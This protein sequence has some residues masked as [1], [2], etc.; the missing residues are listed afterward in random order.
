MRKAKTKQTYDELLELAKE[1]GVENNALFLSA[2]KQY[3]LQMKV[4][5][6]IR[7]AID[8]NESMTCEKVYR[9]KEKNLYADPLI[10]EL[11]RHTDSANKTLLTMLDIVNKLG[12]PI[13]KESALSAFEKEFS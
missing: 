5:E 3:D 8:E 4:I 1:Y 9:G 7:K 10:K 13:K 2:A 6:K 11:P 12:H